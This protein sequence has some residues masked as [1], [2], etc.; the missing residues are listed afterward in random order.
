MSLA[1][2][3]AAVALVAGVLLGARLSLRAKQ[4][5]RLADWFKVSWDDEGIHLELSR[6]R[7]ATTTVPWR[8]VRRVRLKI[9]P[10][11]SDALVL[12]LEDTDQLV[13]IPL[14][15]AGGQEL[16]FELPKRGL[17]TY[18]LIERAMTLAETSVWFPDGPSVG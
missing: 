1:L 17:F 5:A 4:P 6:E 12:W 14:E 2:L 11:L 13:F 7:V 18:E 15:A 3:I 10:R 8:S 9:E 16:L